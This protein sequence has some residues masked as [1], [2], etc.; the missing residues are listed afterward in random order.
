MTH[1]EARRV[2]VERAALW[3]AYEMSWSDEQARYFAEGVLRESESAMAN[4]GWRMVRDVGE[5]TPAP[6]RITP[7]MGDPAEAY[8]GGWNACRAAML[9]EAE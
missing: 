3:L 4:A 9:R 6:T 7:I 2:A 8:A 5:M 1:D